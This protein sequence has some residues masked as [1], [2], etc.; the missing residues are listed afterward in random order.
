MKDEV[1]Y[2]ASLGGL[3]AG[4]WAVC[5]VWHLLPD[6][7]RHS[8]QWW[9]IPAAATSVAAL[10][11]FLFLGAMIGAAICEWTENK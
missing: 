9:F 2:P 8:L 5:Y 3:L 4:V 7:E 6:L 1:M 11:V 10:I